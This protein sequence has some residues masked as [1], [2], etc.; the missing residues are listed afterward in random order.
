MQKAMMMALC[1]ALAALTACSGRQTHA[2]DADSTDNTRAA[3]KGTGITYCD[4]HDCIG[5]IGITDR[6]GEQGV[7][8]FRGQDDAL[9]DS[10][11]APGQTAFRSAFNVYIATGRADYDDTLSHHVILFD[12]GIGPQAGG[13]LLEL[14]QSIGIEPEDI[15]AVCLTH[16]HFDHLGWLLDTAGRVVFPNADIHLSEAEMASG[17]DNE[18]WQQVLAAYGERVKPF[19]GNGKIVDGLVDAEVRSGHTPGHTIYKVGTCLIV[20]DLLHAQDLQL[21]YPDFC[22]RYDADPDRARKVRKS[23]YA[24]SIEHEL[25][26]C[27]AHCYEHFIRMYLTPADSTTK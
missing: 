22:A 4:A 19:A 10:L 18:R 24:E 27:G 23:I 25:T 26:L 2:A 15:D 5:I 7:D 6:E 21:K 20:G 3:A 13:K 8:L 14:M 17:K 1:L 12:A 16:L 11:L 9:L